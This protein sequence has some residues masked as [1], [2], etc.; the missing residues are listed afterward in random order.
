MAAHE[1]G[2]LSRRLLRLHKSL[3]DE[4]R[5]DYESTY[6][7]VDSGELFR[8]LLQGERFAWLRPLSGLIARIDEAL[9]ADPPITAAEVEALRE[10]ARQ[11][12]RPAG[13]DSAFTPRY[14]ETLQRSPEV[15]MDHA[16]VMRVLGPFPKS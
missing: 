4:Q 16:Q 9:E 12:F 15:V 5:R 11:L 1:L 2:E 10:R 13:E 14:H 8:L 3:V 7:P 6:G